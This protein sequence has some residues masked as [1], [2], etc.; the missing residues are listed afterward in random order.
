MDT[1]HCKYSRLKELLAS[2]KSAAIAYSGGVD[3][4]FLLRTAADVLGD[5]AF[6]V[7]A[8]SSS[9]PHREMDEAEAFCREN[10]ILQ[11]VCRTE[12]LSI[13]GFRDNPPDRCYLCKRLIFETL[14]EAALNHGAA[15]LAEGS[16]TDDDGDYRPGR[17]AL[18]ELGVASPLHEAG[19]S[20]AEIRAL[21]KELGLPTWS[22]PSAACL[23]SR[24][25]YGE[26]ITQEKLRMVDEAEAFLQSLGFGQLRV[27]IHGSIARIEVLPE[28]LGRF[29]DAGL[30]SE[31]YAC[32]K[33]LGFTYVTLDLA[34][35]RV[36]SMNE[37]LKPEEMK[38]A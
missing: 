11:V 37:I 14:R 6:A 29:S 15:V 33:A 21:S 3:S 22:K 5:K 23:A 17:I 31:V 32:L 38:R 10:H 35:Y 1:L 34:G 27:R 8:R 19:L 28:E 9:F 26:T 13:P 16:N 25:A 4:T 2:Y 24:F 20:K 12:E 30:R 36:G 7:T 18:R